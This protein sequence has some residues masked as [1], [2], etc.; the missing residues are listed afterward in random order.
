[1]IDPVGIQELNA[2]RTRSVQRWG[3]LLGGG[4]MAVYGVTRRS[5]MGFALAGA[6]GVLAYLGAT[7][8][9]AP[10]EFTAET[11]LLLN[12]APQEAYRFWHNFENFPR[13]MRHLASVNVTGDRRSHWVAYGPL[14]HRI[15]WETEIIDE[16]EPEFITWRSLP[17]SEVSVD[18]TVSFRPAAANRG[19]EVA[20]T[21]TY[22]PPAGAMGKAFAKLMGRDPGF[23]IRQ[24]MRRFKA[25]IETGEAPTTEGQSHGPR[26][27]LTGIF[28]MADPDRSLRRDFDR[29]KNL[30]ELRRMA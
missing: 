2:R 24:D 8:D 12:V 14:G 13:F 4:A 17:G 21:I 7:A 18:G 15:E 23:M 19:T 16:R 6:G 29:G 27:V 28:R 25:L 22:R 10:R 11:S 1:M 9:R 3:A 30:S 26:G 5:R 20:V